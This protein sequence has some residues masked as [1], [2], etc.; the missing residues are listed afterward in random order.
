M[1]AILKK[2][3]CKFKNLSASF[4]RTIFE[5]ILSK[6]TKAIKILDNKNIHTR[7]I[8]IVGGVSNNQYIKEKLENYFTSENIDVYYPLKEMM[9]D[10]AAMIAWAC[11]KTYNKDK[12]N[13]F[14]QPDP[15]M[16]I[17]NKL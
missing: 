9:S 16:K 5:I 15:R 12:S 7:S 3:L 2:L 4:Q 17:S 14:F 1:Q 13:I 10:N 8:S 11:L 6:L